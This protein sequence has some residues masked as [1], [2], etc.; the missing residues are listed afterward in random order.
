MQQIQINCQMSQLSLEFLI[1]FNKMSNLRPKFLQNTNKWRISPGF[2][3]KAN[4]TI[5]NFS[6]SSLKKWLQNIEI[7]EITKKLRNGYISGGGDSLCSFSTAPTDW[8]SGFCKLSSWSSSSSPSSIAGSDTAG[9]RGDAFTAG[10]T[11]GALGAG[12]LTILEGGGNL[13]AFGTSC[14]GVTAAGS[15]AGVETFNEVKVS[16]EKKKIWLNSVPHKR[17]GTPDPEPSREETVSCNW[18]NKN[19][20][21]SAVRQKRI[22]QKRMWTCRWTRT[23]SL[24]GPRAASSPT[25]PMPSFLYRRSELHQ[26]TPTHRVSCDPTDPSTAAGHGATL[27]SSSSAS[28]LSLWLTGTSWRV[29]ASAERSTDTTNIWETEAA[30]SQWPKTSSVHTNTNK[31]QPRI[32][33]EKLYSHHRALW[34]KL[35]QR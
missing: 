19:T 10:A 34:W 13:E 4:K 29:W 7:S 1:F 17:N 22:L 3:S 15:S 8:L 35:L 30:E 26:V 6:Y 12:L 2:C 20:R 9:L 32:P 5:L 14:L 33:S 25:I 23:E 27:T 31:R 24:S 11:G 28:R 18:T 16:S 21:T